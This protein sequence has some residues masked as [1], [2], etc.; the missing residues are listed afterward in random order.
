MDEELMKLALIRKYAKVKGISEERAKE[1]LAPILTDK[2]KIKEYLDILSVVDSIDTKPGSVADEVK[3]TIKAQAITKLGSM[4]TKNEEEDDLES[5]LKKIL[6]WQKE[7]Q[8][9]EKVMGSSQDPRIISLEQKFNNLESTLAKLV[10]TLKENQQNKLT[11]QLAET[12][13]KLNESI[14]KQL[15]D[16][17]SKIEKIEKEEFAFDIEKI[18]EKLERIG[19]KVA[20]PGQNEFDLEK[21]IERLKKL[22]FEV[23]SGYLKAE[24]VKKLIEEEKKKWEQQKREELE[25]EIEKDRV[26][27]TKETVITG[28]KILGETLKE[29]L[30]PIT[31]KIIKET[32]EALEEEEDIEEFNEALEDFEKKR[33]STIETEEET[34]EQKSKDRWIVY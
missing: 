16:L 21:V 4:M 31:R 25:K 29:V 26:E 6:K 19:W 1:L 10:E 13:S 22:G 23:K 11:Q 3:E 24:E 12:I 8:I 18:K 15:S 27:A 14:Q 33:G 32:A 34:P 17:R 30:R 5:T 28:F 7:L 9:I 20:P 2:D